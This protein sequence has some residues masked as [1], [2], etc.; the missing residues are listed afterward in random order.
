M[1]KF[2]NCLAMSVAMLWL[3]GGLYHI[4]FLLR[5][6]DVPGVAL[7]GSV[8]GWYPL[9]SRALI[10]AGAAFSYIYIICHES[11]QVGIS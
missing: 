3:K 10:Y 6:R 8:G 5:W 9:L 2:R 1:I 4:T 11:D 7:A